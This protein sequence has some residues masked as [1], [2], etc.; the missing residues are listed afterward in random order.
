MAYRLENTCFP[1]LLG[2]C[3]QQ[4]LSGTLT[5]SADGATKHVYFEDGAVIYAGSSVV[6]ERFGEQLK[7]IGCISDEQFDVALAETKKGKYL[8]AS[9][10]DLGFLSPEDLR[11]LLLGHV[12]HIIYSLFPWDA[13]DYEFVTQKIQIKDFRQPLPTAEIIFEGIRQMDDPSRIRTWLGDFDRRLMPAR[14]PF[15][16]FQTVSLLPEEAYVISRLDGPVTLTELMVTTGI[17]EEG[18]QR[19]VCAL[20]M[21][22]IVESAEAEH[23][24]VLVESVAESVHPTGSMAVD[25]A[26]AARLCFELSEILRVIDDGGT[27]HQVLG[28]NWRF[29][30]DEL[31]K[32][33]RELAKKFHPDRHSQLAAFDFQ[34]KAELEKVFIR[35]Q[36]AYD[37]L[38]S[39]EARRK[40]EA[41]IRMPGLPPP[42]PSGGIRMPASPTVV[43]PAPPPQTPVSPPR[44]PTPK[45]SPPVPPAALL[46]PVTPVARPIPSPPAPAPPKP[47]SDGLSFGPPKA[48][49]LPPPA[50]LKPVL[51]VTNRTTGAFPSASPVPPRPPAPPAPVRPTAANSAPPPTPPMGNQARPTGAYPNPVAPQPPPRE[52]MLSA[53][54][55]YMKTI[56]FLGNG[57]PE[58]AYQAIRRAI[59]LKPKNADYHALMGRVLAR[60]H[61]KNKEAEKAFRTAID[62]C[63]D[64][65]ELPDLLVELAELYRRFGMESLAVEA[66]DRALGLKPDHQEAKLKRAA[67]G[68]RRT[69]GGHQ[70][71]GTIRNATRQ[72]SSLV[73]KV[74]KRDDKTEDSSGGG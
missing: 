2:A 3:H 47:P 50:L 13:G 54:E 38:N 73:G 23:P 26:E 6:E 43:S 68:G 32:S 12:K 5:V 67:L 16:L 44:T 15:Q 30:S 11:A 22:G 52:S 36:Q 69:T 41:S 20:M 71:P 56:E 46:T 29:S 28:V 49:P 42:T 45:S 19:T 70:A 48:A 60:L 35:I 63:R 39:E 24:P 14:D 53:S 66:L 64:P 31:K 57:D 8:G 27:H 1:K 61:G 7:M 62:L 17:P 25:A 72:I 51:P 21:A 34:V 4:R 37:I 58:R 59:E 18:L 74:F 9:L 55:Y 40:Y 65:E 33:Y 10:V